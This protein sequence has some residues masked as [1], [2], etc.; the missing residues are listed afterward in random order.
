MD[1]K[2]RVSA[3]MSR[4]KHLKSRS[5]I[6]K[7][8]KR[9]SHSRLSKSESTKSKSYIDA[10]QRKESK[11]VGNPNRMLRKESESSTY[12]SSSGSNTVSDNPGGED[13][14]NVGTSVFQPDGEGKTRSLGKFMVGV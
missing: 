11:R 6:H 5:T 9:I 10:S 8:S 3:K 13:N 12:V 14:V 2:N 7:K 4:S 1:S